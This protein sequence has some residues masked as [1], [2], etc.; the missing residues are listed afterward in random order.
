MDK[1]KDKADKKF[2]KSCYHDGYFFVM[3]EKT[4]GALINEYVSDL[5]MKKL[6]NILEQIGYNCITVS[7]YIKLIADK[8]GA[9][10][11]TNWPIGLMMIHK[12]KNVDYIMEMGLYIS[13]VHTDYLKDKGMFDEA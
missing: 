11:D 9:H 6:W 5:E 8:V 10:L 13:T 7:E 4:E 1:V 12:D 3:E 2:F